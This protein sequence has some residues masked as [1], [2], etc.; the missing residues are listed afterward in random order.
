[1]Q[2]GPA[3]RRASRRAHARPRRHAG[4]ERGDGTV[5]ALQRARM[6]AGM[7]GACRDLGAGWV[8]VSDVVSRFGVSRRTFYELFEDRED[9]L[10]AA[11]EEALRRGAER[12]LPAFEAQESWQQA[13]RAGIE[14]LLGF[15]EEDPLYGRL[16][17]VDS[18]GAGDVLLARRRQALEALVDAIDAGRRLPRV[19]AGLARINA[20]G[21]AGAV[22]AILHARLTGTRLP[23][24]SPLAGELAGI[25]VLPYLGRAAAARQAARKTPRARPR[26]A[27]SQLDALAGV[28][29]RLTHRSMR[30]LGVLAEC[31]GR[32]GGLSNRRLGQAAGIADQGQ[33]SKLLK[34][35]AAHGLIV[36]ANHR[37]GRKGQANAWRLTA[38]GAQLQRAIARDAR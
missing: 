12:V 21:A 10:V 9:C 32:R 24:L 29:V 30:V 31:R 1:M 23:R 34:R 22:L 37:P 14:G 33:I 15:L 13:I 3:V 16:L 26:A 35:L 36:N 17:I 38:G 18:L 2:A 25:V 6:L 8:T 20:H 4:G 5:A 7:A 27:A 19:P 11:F 28:D